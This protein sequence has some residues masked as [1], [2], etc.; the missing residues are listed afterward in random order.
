MEK[1][2]YV[3]VL[4]DPRWCGKW[5][6]EGVEFE[7]KPFYIGKGF[8]DRI[9]G[10]FRP[11]SLKKR[12]LKNNIIKA[13]F[14]DGDGKPISIKIYE[15][16]DEKEAFEIEKDLIKHFG[17]LDENNGI[18]ANHT[19]GGDGHS[20]YNKPKPKLRKKVYQY[21]LDG[22]FI[23][24]WDSVFEVGEVLNVGISNISTSVKR[25]GTAYGYIWSY[26]FLGEN[27]KGKIKYQMPV[28]YSNIKQLDKKNGNVIDIFKNALEIEKKMNLRSGARNKIYDCI[29]GK[30][31]TAYGYRWKI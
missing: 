22:K 4:L 10:H 18:L 13:I 28:K 1:K 31:K 3:Y 12:I 7:Y 16:L 5:N 21:G 20:G 17:R 30:L 2:Y 8:G 11:S 19:N 29:N 14:K 26:E 27:L 24:K 23:K 6:Y 9:K 25:S 15:G